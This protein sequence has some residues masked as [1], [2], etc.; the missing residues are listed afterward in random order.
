[1][2]QNLRVILSNDAA[3]RQQRTEKPLLGGNTRVTNQKEKTKI[4]EEANT[5]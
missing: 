3:G 2:E 5:T 4:K 1:M